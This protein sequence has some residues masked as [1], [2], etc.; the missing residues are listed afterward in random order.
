MTE[1][2]IERAIEILNAVAFDRRDDYALTPGRLFVCSYRCRDAKEDDYR[3]YGYTTA[4]A[5]AKSIEH[6]RAERDAARKLA[7]SLGV[8]GVTVNAT[9]EGGGKIKRPPLDGFDDDQF[10]IEVERIYN[11][12]SIPEYMRD[13]EIWK[14]GYQNGIEAA[15][16][17]A[18]RWCRDGIP[19]EDGW[20]RL[21]SL[22]GGRTPCGGN[23]LRRELGK[24]KI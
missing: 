1:M 6:L 15:A 18:C 19:L 22:S 12:A 23:P 21:A 2:T 11:D 20:H 3:D 4:L 13:V 8:R 24:E 14:A 16:V 9:Y 7:E 5:I 17:F 10:D